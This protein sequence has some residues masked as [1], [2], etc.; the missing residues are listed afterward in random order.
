MLSPCSMS[1]SSLAPRKNSDKNRQ[2]MNMF[3]D[4]KRV[5]RNSM[6]AVSVFETSR[7]YC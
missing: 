1:S 4:Q 6:S 2:N 5:Y 3:I 7:M